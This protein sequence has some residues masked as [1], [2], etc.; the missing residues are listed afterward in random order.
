MPEPIFL[1]SPPPV[2]GTDEAFDAAL[3]RANAAVGARR[4]DYREGRSWSYMDLRPTATDGDALIHWLAADIGGHVQ[5]WLDRHPNFPVAVEGLGAGGVLRRHAAQLLLLFAFAEVARRFQTGSGVWPVIREHCSPSLRLALFNGQGAYLHSQVMK[6]LTGA[7]GL[8]N[9]YAV[10]G[11]Y[12]VTLIR[13]QVGFTRHDLEREDEPLVGALKRSARELKREGGDNFSEEFAGLANL[14]WR[15]RVETARGDYGLKRADIEARLRRNCW[16]PEPWA[17]SEGL[18]FDP[19]PRLLAAAERGAEEDA[20]AGADAVAL[21]PPPRLVFGGN[22]ATF[23]VEIPTSLVA[24]LACGAESCVLE[25]RPLVGPAVELCRFYDNGDGTYAAGGAAPVP[26]SANGADLALLADGAVVWAGRLDLWD[27]GADAT[28]YRASD[29]DRL[30]RPPVASAGCLAVVADGV[31][32]DPPPAAWVRLGPGWRACHLPT[33]TALA[34]ASGAVRLVSGGRA[35]WRLDE[36]PAG[37]SAD[38]PPWLRRAS[39]KIFGG[40]YHLGKGVFVDV[41][42]P[43]G[44]AVTDARDSGG[45]PI[46]VAAKTGGRFRVGPVPVPVSGRPLARAWLDVVAPPELGAAAEAVRLA[47]SLAVRTLGAAVDCGGGAAVLDPAGQLDLSGCGAATFRLDADLGSG[48]GRSEVSQ[49]ALLVIEGESVVR[50][51]PEAATAGHANRIALPNLSGYGGR[52]SVRRAFNEPRN[53]LRRDRLTVAGRVVDFGILL[54]FDDP[55]AEPVDGAA[56]E[57]SIRPRETAV[58]VRGGT[59]LDQDRHR[60]VAWHA[61]GRWRQCRPRDAGGGR[62]AFE[63]HDEAK[64]GRVL[65]VAVASVKARVGV[66]WR[67]NWA[68]ALAAASASN[69]S[70]VIAAAMRGLRWAKLPVLDGASGGGDSHGPAARLPAAEFACRHAALTLPVALADDCPGPV[71]ATRCPDNAFAWRDVARSLFRGWEP[72]RDGANAAVES[73]GGG[74]DDGCWV[75]AAER[76]FAFDPIIGAKLALRLPE[77]VA[78]KAARMMYAAVASR[79]TGLDIGAIMARP[80]AELRARMDQTCEAAAKHELI[81]SDQPADAHFLMRAFIEPAVNFAVGRT[82]WAGLQKS[83]PNAARGLALLDDV[84]PFAELLEARLFLELFD[85]AG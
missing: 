4:L 36:T 71:P 79:R 55:A 39:A 67:D 37:V 27:D 9:V 18:A 80:A 85:R 83:N 16:V 33:G 13:M 47:V 58:L 81:R 8:R 17:T 63:P 20:A 41:G 46:E 22:S 59:V 25:A 2:G 45:I 29:G 43:E 64:T 12:H 61:D 6:E 78:P 15:W 23:A 66:A 19:V 75:D 3:T 72:T 73:L 26:P 62:W 11:H 53:F 32:L 7:V 74:I 48:D 68:D 14:L 34:G 54:G 82:T 21:V 35:L 52:L 49:R 77:T 38:A 50:R 84:A 51:M 60:I 69:D 70:A 10:K 65:A 44:A 24:E 30:D 40:P 5:R 57:E 31:D 1:D 42:L 28:F 56:I 76:L